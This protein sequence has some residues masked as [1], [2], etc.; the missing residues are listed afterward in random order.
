MAVT[1]VQE[2]IAIKI[3]YWQSNEEALQGSSALLVTL[4]LSGPSR[5][6][7]RFSADTKLEVKRAS[8]ISSRALT[9]ATALGAFRL[10]WHCAAAPTLFTSP[11]LTDRLRAPEHAKTSSVVSERVWLAQSS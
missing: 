10:P 11:L 6:S 2:G 8:A 1:I 9:S 3:P 4:L 7:L 5:S